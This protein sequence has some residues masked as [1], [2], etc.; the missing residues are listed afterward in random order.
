AGNYRY[1]IEG[2]TY[3]ASG[4]L[5]GLAAGIYNLIVMDDI[6]CEATISVQISATD[7]VN[8]TNITVVDSGCGTTNGSINISVDST[9][10]AVTY[11]LNGGAFGA[12][13]SFSG[14]AP[15]Q[16]T[17]GVKDAG[18]CITTGTALVKFGVPFAAIRAVMDANCT[19]SGCHVAGA[20]SP[21]LTVDANVVA[22]ADKI[23][24]Q[25]GSKRMPLKSSGKTL[26]PKEIAD[27]A[28]WVDD[29]ASL[30]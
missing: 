18:G 13:S 7:G 2:G 4:T 23:K 24:T 9:N 28:C 8:I 1:K 17:V 27:I 10:P 3:Q 20:R 6:G 11:Q 16:Y 19:L 14:L 26:T 5:S 30:N 12:S 29:G 25:T 21:D 15:G 22:F